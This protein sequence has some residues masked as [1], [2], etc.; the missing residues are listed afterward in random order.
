MDIYIYNI[1]WIKYFAF[2]NI[3]KHNM[4]YISLIIIFFFLVWLKFYKIVCVYY[5]T[6]IVCIPKYI[7]KLYITQ[8]I[9]L[10]VFLL[11]FKYFKTEEY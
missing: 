11:I 4:C 9:L 3:H 10:T 1:I 7:I 8:V 2:S 5:N 6:I